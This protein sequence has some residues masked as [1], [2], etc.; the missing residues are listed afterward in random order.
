MTQE[1]P[2]KFSELLFLTLISSLGKLVWSGNA[3]G[4]VPRKP[5]SSD[6][7]DGYV[8]GLGFGCLFQQFPDSVEEMFVGYAGQ[9]ARSFT[10]ANR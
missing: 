8:L 6:A 7:L 9:Y 10:E 4:L 5:N 1:P 2:P 3:G